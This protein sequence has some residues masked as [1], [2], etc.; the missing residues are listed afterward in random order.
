MKSCSM[1]VAY[2]DQGHLAEQVCENKPIDAN[3]AVESA[4]ELSSSSSRS[5]KFAII[6]P[7]E[8]ISIFTKLAQVILVRLAKCK[9][10]LKLPMKDCP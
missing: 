5:F 9:T 8:S 7:A 10:T 6:P 1:E 4:S 3:Y 2:N